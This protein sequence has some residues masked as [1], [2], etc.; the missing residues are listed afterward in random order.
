MTL[1]PICLRNKGDFTSPVSTNSTTPATKTAEYLYPVTDR[2]QQVLV[3][4][5]HEERNN[6]VGKSATYL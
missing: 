3:V 1:P 4:E 6:A 2:I 5:L